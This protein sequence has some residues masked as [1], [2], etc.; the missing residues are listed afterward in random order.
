MVAVFTTGLTAS[1]SAFVPRI[2]FLLHK[3]LK[4]NICTP[5]T[6]SIF[7]RSAPRLLCGKV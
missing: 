7:D 1:N 5:F 2:V 6:V 4:I 3:I